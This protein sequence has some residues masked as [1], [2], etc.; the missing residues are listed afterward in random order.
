MLP[1]VSSFG[2]GIEFR[3]DLVPKSTRKPGQSSVSGRYQGLKSAFEQAGEYGC[4]TAGTDCNDDRGTVDDRGHNEITQF[5]LIDDIDRYGMSHRG[6][7]DLLIDGPIVSCGHHQVHT[8]D[9]VWT[10]PAFQMGD[11]LLL[12]EVKDMIIPRL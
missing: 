8:F 9:Q 7:R 6:L 1:E 4:R 10:K 12:N 3:L 5:G 11:F 2:D